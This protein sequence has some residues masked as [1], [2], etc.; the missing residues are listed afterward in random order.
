MEPKQRRFRHE[1]FPG[2]LEGGGGLRGARGAP[3]VD[4][5]GLEA[6]VSVEPGALAVEAGERHEED[7]AEPSQEQLHQAPNDAESSA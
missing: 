1:P 6:L 2:C 7:D 3:Q 5:D 4:V